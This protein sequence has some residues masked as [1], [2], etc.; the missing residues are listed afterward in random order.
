MVSSGNWKFGVHSIG[1]LFFPL[2]VG[3]LFVCVFVCCNLGP[4]MDANSNN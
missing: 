1:L 2:F 3:L 4:I